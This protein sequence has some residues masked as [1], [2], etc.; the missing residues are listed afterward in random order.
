M[1]MSILSGI[2]K[3]ANTVADIWGTIG[4]GLSAFWLSIYTILMFVIFVVAFV[5]IQLFVFGQIVVIA[6]MLWKSKAW[7]ERVGIIPV[8]KKPSVVTGIKM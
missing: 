2:D 7:L 4:S 5:G 8:R 3:L 1:S 6:G